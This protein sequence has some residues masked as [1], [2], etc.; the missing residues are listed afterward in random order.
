MIPL[1]GGVANALFSLIIILFL[2]LYLLAEPDLY[3]KR[4]IKYTPLSYRGRMVHILARM[5]STIRAWLRIT[6]VSMIVTAFLTGLGLALVRA[7]VELHH[8]QI[9]LSSDVG[10]GSCFRVTLPLSPSTSSA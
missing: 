2:S 8:G 6:V 5:D 9:H 3:I 4:I 10:K 7:I 1:V